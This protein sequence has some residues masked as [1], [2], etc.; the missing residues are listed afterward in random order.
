MP[1]SKPPSNFGF[2]NPNLDPKHHPTSW[3][4]F[5]CYFLCL[6]VCQLTSTTVLPCLRI[7]VE[8]ICVKA[9]MFGTNLRKISCF[10]CIICAGHEVINEV[11]HLQNQSEQLSR[12]YESS[13][14]H[15]IGVRMGWCALYT[16]FELQNRILC[17]Y[18]R[19]FF[20]HVG[21]QLL[22]TDHT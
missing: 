22:F 1:D 19:I 14:Q 7:I 12:Y 3:K 20:S 10:L 18:S 17:K 6:C 5:D 13:R 15:G 4:K 21:I 11:K 9:V 16:V 2:G 8:V